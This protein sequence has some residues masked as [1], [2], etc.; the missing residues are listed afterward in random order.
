[1][2][3]AEKILALYDGKRTTREIAD[4]VGCDTP[5]VRVVARQRKGTGKSVHDKRYSAS[6]LGKLSRSR[7][8][9]AYRENCKAKYGV[10]ANGHR[11]RTD[12]EFRKR[13]LAENM[14]RYYRKK[15]QREEA[16]CPPG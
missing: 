2:T 12:P 11:Y 16:P 3:K 4:I 9:H 1:M 13:K 8:N 7:S 10:T 5:Y 6:P 14:A 15:A